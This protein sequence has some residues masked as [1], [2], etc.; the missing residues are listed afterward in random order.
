MN[1][2]K[3]APLRLALEAKSIFFCL[4]ALLKQHH[5]AYGI[6]LPNK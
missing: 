3:T 5:D 6:C 1:K 4:A 2:A